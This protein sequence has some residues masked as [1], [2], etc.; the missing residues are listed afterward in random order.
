MSS[1]E[2]AK[3]GFTYAAG[4]SYSAYGD[5]N[6]PMPNMSRYGLDHYGRY[7]EN[8]YDY[9]GRSESSL[10]VSRNSSSS[11]RGL[12]FS[13][14][15][16][17]LIS[18]PEPSMS[19]RDYLTR[20]VKRTV[21]TTTTTTDHNRH[22]STDLYGETDASFPGRITPESRSGNDMSERNDRSYTSTTAQ[23]ADSTADSSNMVDWNYGPVSSRT[24]T[25][26][27]AMASY[28]STDRSSIRRVH[29]VE[30]AVSEPDRSAVEQIT[31]RFIDIVT[32]NTITNTENV[33]LEDSRERK[34]GLSWCCLLPLLLFLLL[35]PLLG[36]LWWFGVP[37]AVREKAASAQSVIYNFYRD[38]SVRSAEP[39][40][41]SIF[42]VPPIVA[43]H[44]ETN[45]TNPLPPQIIYVREPA[46]TCPVVKTCCDD[47]QLVQS[48]VA[49]I[50]ARLETL[51]RD[52]DVE[53]DEWQKNRQSTDEET[54]RSID[55]LRLMLVRVEKEIVIRG[56]IVPQSVIER[57]S[58]SLE[59]VRRLVVEN[60]RRYDEDKTGEPD[61][62]LESS[63][64][65]VISTRCSED[66]KW[67]HSQLSLFGIPIPFTSWTTSPRLA[68][69][70]DMKPGQ[71]WAFKGNQGYL[72][73]KLTGDVHPTS[74]S[75][76]HLPK[77]LSPTGKIDSAPKDFEVYGL[78]SEQ[79][80]GYILGTYTYEDNG[81]S[82]QNFQIKT[83]LYPEDTFSFV[84]LRITSN[85]GHPE[86]TC[87]YR[88]RVH[89]LLVKRDE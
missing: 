3:T 11:A 64:A 9:S 61:Y 89:G 77:N 4:L 84:E 62:A 24:R 29:Q 25:R 59:D 40:K 51:Q 1:D 41:E 20:L 36:G 81:Q 49:L 46:A 35:L 78:V 86:Y 13:D 68:I 74:F 45:K 54:R 15:S 33:R 56:Q 80:P 88:F 7:T 47:V 18:T 27:P 22:D 67:G 39:A 6:Q 79:G 10:S 26:T 66:Y 38:L 17:S 14:S 72:V 76:E 82:L 55:E 75:L 8:G 5:P 34:R 71:C 83:K 30:E 70:P 32:R 43:S 21:T 53:R 42:I 23:A 69:Q 58:F 57:E 65:T 50:L 44:N 12:D 48:Q 87:L 28:L 73:I 60:I 52:K 37:L 16:R 31:R 63:G 2:K 19:I 85:H